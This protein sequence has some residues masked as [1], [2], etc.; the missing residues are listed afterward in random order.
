MKKILLILLIWTITIFFWRYLDNIYS[1]DELLEKS[2]RYLS[3]GDTV[4]ASSLINKAIERNPREPNYYRIKAKILLVESVY[5][6]QEGKELIKESVLR[7]LQISIDENPNNLVT[8]RNCIP[9]YYFLTLKDA[10]VSGVPFDIDEKYLPITKDYY[11]WVKSKYSH[12]AGVIVTLAKYEKRLG[13]TQ[14]YNKSV[15]IIKKIRPDLLDW[16]ES[17]R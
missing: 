14:D 5:Q 3:K 9:L 17:F 1:A 11:Q 16:Y 6:D 10:S 7:E 13:L 4:M 2:Q 15:E 8:I 12:D